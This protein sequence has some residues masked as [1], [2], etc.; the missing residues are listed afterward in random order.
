MCGIDLMIGLDQVLFVLLR[1]RLKDAIRI[2][3]VASAEG[4]LLFLIECSREVVEDIDRGG[5]DPVGR[6]FI[7]GEGLSGSRVAGKELDVGV[8]VL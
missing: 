3:S 8:V 4:L 6:N 5:I 7:A 2:G 1:C